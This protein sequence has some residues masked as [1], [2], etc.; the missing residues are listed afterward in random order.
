MKELAIGFP[1][2]G[3]RDCEDDVVMMM[4][5]DDGLLRWEMG[6]G[7]CNIDGILLFIPACLRSF[8]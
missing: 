2:V 5:D 8:S 7:R 3:A 6:D 4:M 1:L